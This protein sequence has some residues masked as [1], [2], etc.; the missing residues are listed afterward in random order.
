MGKCVHRQ[1][2]KGAKGQK[3]KADSLLIF[4]ILRTIS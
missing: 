1:M 3:V 2:D 4:Y